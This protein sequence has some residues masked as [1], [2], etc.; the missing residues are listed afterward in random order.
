MLDNLLTE[1]NCLE[2]TVVWFDRR[3]LRIPS[4]EHV[5][6][7]KIS[8]KIEIKM[9]DIIRIRMRQLTVVRGKMY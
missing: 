2:A 5:S 6:N 7:E 3:I 4:T 8:R 9:P 1:K